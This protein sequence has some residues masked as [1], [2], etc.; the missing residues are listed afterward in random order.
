MDAPMYATPITL[1]ASHA[2]TGASFSG[3]LRGCVAEVYL[4][5]RQLSERELARAAGGFDYL[6]AKLEYNLLLAVYAMEAGMGTELA[7]ALGESEA[8]ELLGTAGYVVVGGLCEVLLLVQCRRLN[9]AIVVVCKQ[10]GDL[11]WCG[12]AIRW[13]AAPSE[14][15]L[16]PTSTT[17]TTV[18]TSNLTSAALPA[19]S[20]A[21]ALSPI[22]TAPTASSPAAFA[23]AT[24]QATHP[25]P[26][27]AVPPASPTRGSQRDAGEDDAR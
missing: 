15:L 25:T 16:I 4:W 5:G 3:N 26:V 22:P 18:A 1:M 8:A 27:T 17:A 9:I 6:A 7:D 24:A 10:S 12:Y 13:R 20:S 19:V 2:A 11:E 21:A 14:H 23:T